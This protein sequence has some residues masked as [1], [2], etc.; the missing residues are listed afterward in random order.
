MSDVTDLGAEPPHGDQAG[1]NAKALREITRACGVALM[2]TTAALEEGAEIDEAVSP[3]DLVLLAFAARGRRLLRSI[4]RLIDV[5]ERAEAAPSMRVLQEQLI[6]S[7]WLL[8]DP[9]KHLD[10]WT[11]EDLRKRDVVTARI[12]ADDGL[13]EET[14][15]VIREE[16]A[17]AREQIREF[18]EAEPEG[19]DEDGEICPTCERPLK[20]KREAGLPPIE[21]MAA[22]TGLSFA[23]NLAYRL[24][25]QADIHAT[26]L[27]VDNTLVRLENGRIAIRE[28][29]DFSLS[30]YDSYQVG[31]HI[32]LD[33]VRPIA[34]RWPALGWET[35]LL[36]IE[37]TLTATKRADPGYVPRSRTDT[38]SPADGG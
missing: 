30:A 10:L 26:A 2:G 32:Y 8:L 20:K 36:G 12:L 4:Y 17:R 19:A 35:T 31:A 28:E 18:I 22:M 33:L 29:P 38:A 13:D 7:R 23:Y 34:E 24:Q 16:E 11:R 3:I 5:G 37:E 9:E 25:S 6:V 27:V 15:A 14:K 21:Q 1:R